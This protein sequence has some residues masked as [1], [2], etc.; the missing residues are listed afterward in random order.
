M[1]GMISLDT[2]PLTGS[3]RWGGREVSLSIIY[4]D[5]CSLWAEYWYLEDEAGLVHL[6]LVVR[7]CRRT[8][9]GHLH[10]RYFR[11]SPDVCKMLS[12]HHHLLFAVAFCRGIGDGRRHHSNVRCG[13]FVAGQVMTSLNI[14][15]FLGTPLEHV[16]DQHPVYMQQGSKCVSKISITMY[17]QLKHYLWEFGMPFKVF[18]RC[19]RAWKYYSCDAVWAKPKSRKSGMTTTHLDLFCAWIAIYI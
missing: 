14:E 12:C 1:D 13:S 17:L 4:H 8:S 5:V 6:F 11:I 10:D 7:C 2:L 19:L 16:T 9:K 18:I 15:D 3:C